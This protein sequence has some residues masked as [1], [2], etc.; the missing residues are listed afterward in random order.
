MLEVGVE[1][2]QRPILV[3]GMARSGTTWIARML[4]AS[5]QLGYINEP[6][7][8]S[9]PT[10]ILALPVDHWYPYITEAN[11]AEILPGLGDLLRFKYGFLGELLR[12]RTRTDAVHAAKTWRHFARVRNRRPLVKEPHAVFSAKWFAERLGCQVV[13]A[14]RHPAAVVSSWK[15]LGWNFDFRHLLEQPA[16]MREWLAPYKR[17][18]EEALSPKACLVHRVA[19]LWRLIYAVV[20]EYESRFPDFHIVRHERLSWNPIEEFADLFDALDLE[21][22]PRAAQA[23]KTSSATANP[24]ES[25]IEDPHATE[26][27][28]RES[29]QNW[30]QRLTLDEISRIRDI[31]DDVARAHYGEVDW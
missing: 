14:V 30:K 1:R 27:N 12:A 9:A 29:L 25:A 18:M 20:G 17:E 10:G 2:G 31:T 5:E 28:S 13:I 15:R 22:T 26:L 21:F 3:T 8:L 6:L 7:N 24:S 11:E 23:I 19:L 4:E 16:L